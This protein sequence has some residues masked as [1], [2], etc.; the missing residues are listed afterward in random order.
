MKAGLK[1]QD[2]GFVEAEYQKNLK[3]A[4]DLETSGRALSALHEYKSLALD[5]KGLIDVAEVEEK[6]SVLK[7]SA[8]LQKLQ[9]DK[10]TSEDNEL[11]AHTRLGLRLPPRRGG[12]CRHR[13]GIEVAP[14]SSASVEV[15]VF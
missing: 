10:R 4:A 14:G 12:I 2:V 6:I 1:E 3:A 11:S 8:D 7:T 13:G 9:K 5:F 15:H